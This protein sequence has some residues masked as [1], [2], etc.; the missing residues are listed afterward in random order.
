MARARQRQ[1]A[2]VQVEHFAE[3]QLTY[4]VIAGV[5]DERFDAGSVTSSI[6][7]K[8][9][10]VNCA[11]VTRISSFGV[12][13]WLQLM[14]V[15][16]QKAEKLFFVECSS[17]FVDQLNMFAGFAGRG[18]IISFYAP[19]ACEGCGAARPILFRVDQDKDMIE[20]GQPPSY[21]CRVCRGQEHFDDDPNT[22]FEWYVQQGPV[23]VDNAVVALLRARLDYS[24][25]GQ[26]ARPQ[27]EKHVSGTQTFVAIKGTLDS[28]LPT[29][30][31]VGGL[32]GM[33]VIDT[34]GIVF[35]QQAG[36]Q[37]WEE[38]L[39]HLH[40]DPAIQHVYFSGLPPLTVER[41][42]MLARD[43]G[44]RFTVLSVTLQYECGSCS[45]ATWHQV[46]ISARGRGHFDVQTLPTKRCSDCGSHLNVM[47]SSSLL[48]S[49]NQLPS[50]KVPNAIKRFVQKAPAQL[51]AQRSRF[52]AKKSET[53]LGAPPKVLWA[54]VIGGLFVLGG[55]GAAVAIFLKNQANLSPPVSAPNA[56][57]E[58]A[59][60]DD[61]TKLRPDWISSAQPSSAWCFDTP[62][63]SY[64]TGVS[65]YR[66]TTEEALDEAS[67]ASL[68]ELVSL[69]V[70]RAD[71]KVIETQNELYAETRQQ[72]LSNLDKLRQDSDRP[73]LAE[74]FAKLRETRA[75][76]AA[77]LRA[78]GGAAVPT[79]QSDSYWEEYERLS[80]G[81]T[82]FL[83]F[84]RIEISNAA[85]DALVKR[86][87]KTQTVAG[88][89]VAPA[90]PGLA[91]RVR[92][93]VEG[94]FVVDGGRGKLSAAGAKKDQIIR[95]LG[96]KTAKDPDS[97]IS[98]IEGADSSLELLKLDL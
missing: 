93:S 15:I 25:S 89:T 58:P 63:K 36:L 7:T 6:N 5:I 84:V 23:E 55:V 87:S 59:K 61:L 38:L 33:V 90:F 27:V 26:T 57:V 49:L 82:E 11:R 70:L 77:S 86:Y 72:A 85:L 96:K 42:S 17:K 10:V 60:K 83:G 29:A 3:G 66:S 88:A 64:C 51:E 98:A 19:Y 97:L 31:I 76:V 18:Q 92:E 95:G 44:Q 24:P 67:D 52:K 56:I 45:A 2:N 22:Y 73:E 30:K 8:L 4:I 75:A 35:I 74:T 50:P 43:Q 39:T 48:A 71:S 1:S 69:L 80:G 20:R 21:T 79:Q 37:A 41:G 54:T 32:E 91:W 78:T 94:L 65:S 46:P 81:G 53:Q 13:Q 62:V 16:E 14:E 68:E 47:A 9:V 34:S 12:R 28:S 40:R